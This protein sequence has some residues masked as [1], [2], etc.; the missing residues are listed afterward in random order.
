MKEIQPM[1]I[2]L[3][4]MVLAAAQPITMIGPGGL[5]LVIPHLFAAPVSILWMGL[6]KS[7]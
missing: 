7:K 1:P 2:W 6:Q 4:K 3:R 5:L